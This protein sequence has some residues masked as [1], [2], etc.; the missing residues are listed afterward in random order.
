MEYVDFYKSLI[1]L[2]FP[3]VVAAFLLVKL[4]KSMKN[5][6]IAIVNLTIELKNVKS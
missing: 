3:V 6:E 4:D 2:G 1:E 5:I